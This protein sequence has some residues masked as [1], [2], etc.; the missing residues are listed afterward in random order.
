MPAPPASPAPPR[1]LQ[2]VRPRWSGAILVCGKCA[3]KHEDGKAIRGALKDAAVRHLAAATGQRKL[4]II[5]TACLG[6]CPKNAIVAAS[7]A[8]LAACEVVLLRGERDVAGAL[9]RLL[10]PAG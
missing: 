2:I 5:K 4:K 3:R 6:L 10:P 7:A 8:S 1:A 9:S